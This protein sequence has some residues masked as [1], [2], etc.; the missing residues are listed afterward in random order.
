MANY[1]PVLLVSVAAHS[2]PDDSSVST[3]PRGQVDYLSHNW[4]EEDVWKSWRNMTRQKNEIANGV[5]LENASWRT[6]WKQ[7][8]G[9]GTVTPETLNWLKDSDVTWLYGPLH[10]AVD[11]T[12]PPKP[13][14]SATSALDLSTSAT[15]THKP[16]LKHR[17]ISQ[18][19]TSDLPVSPIFS[20]PDSEDD[21]EA[22]QQPDDPGGS[23]PSSR[24]PTLLHTKSDTHITRWGPNRAFRK[25][26]PPRINPPAQTQAHQ[27]LGSNVYSPTNLEAYFSNSNPSSDTQPLPQATT[28][29]ATGQK[30][31][32]ISFNT[33]VE[34]CIAIEKPNKRPGYADDDD[35]DEEDSVD[36]RDY[37][38]RG[39]GARYPLG[40]NAWGYD[41][42][43]EEDEE[44]DSE[45]E[46]EAVS[47]SMWDER[48]SGSRSAVSGSDSDSYDPDE[49]VGDEDGGTEDQEDDGIVEMRRFNSRSVN[50][51]PTLP[52]SQSTASSSSS[53]STS[54]SVSNTSTSSASTSASPD[55]RKSSQRRL[56]TSTTA[57]YRPT[58]SSRTTSYSDN[59]SS[60]LNP[61]RHR[62]VAPPL[63]RTSTSDR[64]GSAM[65]STAAQS[66]HVTIAPIAPT[67]LKTG[68]HPYY[69]QPAGG[70]VEG[71]GDEGAGSDDGLWGHGA[72][73][74]AA[75]WW[76]VHHTKGNGRGRRSEGEESDGDGQTP[77]ELVYV[78]PFG[79]NYSLRAGRDRQREKE[80]RMFVR[81]REREREQQERERLE[82]EGRRS[83]AIVDTA[84]DVMENHED[85]YG[86]GDQEVYARRGTLFSVGGED[87]VH[88]DDVTSSPL[89]GV[90]MGASV[91]KV[92]V[93]HD[94]YDNFG[95]PDLG[96][97][98]PLQRS[99]SS[100]SL[101]RDIAGGL[102]SNLSRGRGRSATA[103]SP[104]QRADIL[105]ERERSSRSRSRSRSRTPSPAL[106]LPST[107]L[108]S[109]G[110]STSSASVPSSVPRSDH[111]QQKHAPAPVPVPIRRTSS[112]SPT[113]TSLPAST[114]LLSPPLRGR[115][116]YQS[117][118]SYAAQVQDNGRET[119]GRSS[120]RTASSSVSDRDRSTGHS[121]SI[122]SLSPDGIELGTCAGGR[123]DRERER[124]REKKAERSR[125]RERNE[126][127]RMSL[128]QGSAQSASSSSP[129]GVQDSIL[130][131]SPASTVPP[132]V[133]YAQDVETPSRLNMVPG[134]KFTT[135]SSSS[136]C[137]T[138]S[139]TATV[140]H[141]HRSPAA[142][143]ALPS[144]GDSSPIPK[145]IPIDMR[146][147][148][149]Q[150][151]NLQPTPSNSPIIFMKPI[152]AA[153]AAALAAESSS[154][155]SSPSNSNSTSTIS[156]TPTPSSPTYTTKTKSPLSVPAPHP[157]EPST[158]YS[159][160]PPRGVDS[161][162][163]SPT[164][165]PSRGPVGDAAG[166][167]EP[168]IMGKA[169]EIVSSA[170]AFL[171]LWHHS[172]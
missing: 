49:G 45:D 7:R 84:E 6:W 17:S 91:P 169:V 122:G 86:N 109:T 77:V 166:A 138:T 48:Y 93:R 108:I 31:R 160:S 41:D 83:G 137:S 9:L 43:Y 105:G 4:E 96:E 170:G 97:G 26:S 98:P 69:G 131:V 145:P 35:D 142:P 165:S 18:L 127:K 146:I 112:S 172:P 21:S 99:S 30:K 51:K 141:A 36:V 47:L 71:L 55:G 72:A 163:S 144:A 44:E 52:R 110:S 80:Q 119:R 1:L 134:T 38:N 124:E 157:V 116:S 65:S 155:P 120:T 143:P 66:I 132:P 40:R 28:A 62:R 153:V 16:I 114:S 147:V 73:G 13:T 161:A 121:S 115:G 118:Y 150:A 89:T 64:P 103:S 113:S 85:G 53:A 25:D 39:A 59:S 106:I 159:I 29:S 135:S 125:G 56:S 117:S 20:P 81:E 104:S 57:T 5:R 75:R 136:S 79:S 171:G 2:I 22:L 102:S 87:D 27:T 111:Q 15:P 123:V 100:T 151:R 90:H 149:E 50:N 129:D 61:R 148:E 154:N 8:N 130:R 162:P 128:G 42:G 158:S 23:Y 32:H 70:W 167:A 19:L 82:E 168:S 156:T 33:F 46:A 92:V 10:T 74:A 14:A 107:S 133:L 76:G 12:P 60:A 78:P 58:P 37:A 139:S 3:L 94:A 24:R 34:Q 11:W 88:G 101:N 67:I 68:S 126:A 164:R 63:I 152:P 54:T 95:G 140:T